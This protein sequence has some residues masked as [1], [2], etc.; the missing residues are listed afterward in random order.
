MMKRM[1]HRI[2]AIGLTLALLAGAAL[3]DDNSYGQV[4]KH[5]K[6]NYR[7]KQQGFFGM[8]MLAR[9]AVKFI[10]PAG[11]KNFKLTMLRELDYSNGPAPESQDFHAFLR[12]KVGPGWMP[13]VTYS[14]PRQQQWTYV[15]AL[16]EKEDMKLLVVTVQKQDAVVLQAKFNPARLVEFMN[17]PQIMGVSLKDERGQKPPTADGPRAEG[18]DDSPS[19][20][21]VGPT[22]I[23]RICLLGLH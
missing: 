19:I 6:S 4:V 14:A 15:Y 1:P 22:D 17:N 21:T 16:Q 9:F 5:I 2:A 18:D 8:M 12:S 13:L 11:V 3:A 20:L 10:K 7:A 23:T